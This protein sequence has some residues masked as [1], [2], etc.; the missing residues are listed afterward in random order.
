MKIT[1]LSLFN[2]RGFEFA[3]FT[4]NPQFN[5][6]AGINGAGKSTV[7][8][9]IGACASHIHRQ[10]QSVRINPFGFDAEDIRFGSPFADA[11]IYFSLD[12]HE[13]RFT[14]REWREAV[15]RDDPANI[16]RLRREILEIER[17]GER[18]R[19]LM[20]ELADTLSSPEPTLFNPPVADMKGWAAQERSA[21]LVMHFSTRRSMLTE[22][23]VEGSKTVAAKYPAYFN[24][25]RNSMLSIVQTADRMRAQR[26]Q[27]AEHPPSRR[28]VELLEEAISTF[29]PQFSNLRPSEEGPPRILIDYEGVTLDIRQLSDGERSV[30]VLILDI[31]RRL[32]QA[33]PTLEDP[34]REAEAVILID[35]IDLHLH[36]QWQRK[37]VGDLTRTFPNCQFIATTHSPQVI[38]EVAHEQIQMIDGDNVFV[39]SHSFGVDSSRVLEE[40]MNT[41]P[42]NASVE[43]RLATIARLIDAQKTEDA[44]TALKALAEEIGESD[45]EVVRAKLLLDFLEGDDE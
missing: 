14:L 35:E 17:P 31:A 28:A 32:T 29:L 37:I 8:D 30:L 16:E 25:L 36:P 2:L 38:G 34:M 3:E 6:I 9:T 27:A 13:C 23:D 40:L 43:G 41:A 7:L 33:N 22:R 20:R 24:A 19:T 11:T 39:P 21:P 12:G 15:V 44:R 10:V 4:F 5:L 26:V 1:S 45:P 18:P 42:R